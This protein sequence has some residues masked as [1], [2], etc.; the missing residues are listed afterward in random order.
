MPNIDVGHAGPV[1]ADDSLDRGGGGD[2]VKD[3]EGRFVTVTAIA[4]PDVSEV[5]H[6]KP[7]VPIRI[8]GDV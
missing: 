8:V 3:V 2:S 1:A 4:E 6:S 7:G 5:R